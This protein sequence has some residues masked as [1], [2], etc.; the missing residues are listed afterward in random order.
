MIAVPAT[1]NPGRTR[2]STNG[3]CQLEKTENLASKGPS[4]GN[5]RGSPTRRS[6]FSGE[7]PKPQ[8]VLNVWDRTAVPKRRNAV[9][10]NAP[11]VRS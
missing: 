3:T 5:L 4:A 11:P 10:K 7:L 6:S 8:H 2:L 9:N 1:W